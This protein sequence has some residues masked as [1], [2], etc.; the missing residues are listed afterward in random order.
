M[1]LGLSV[2]S[3]L[4][5][6]AVA[7]SQK[8][9]AVTRIHNKSDAFEH[10]EVG[11]ATQYLRST[12][13][14]VEQFIVIDESR[15]KQKL[16]E[17]VDREKKK[18]YKECYSKS[19]QIP[20]G[21]QLAADSLLR[22]QLIQFDS[23][24]CLFS[25]ELIDLA[26]EA[27]IGGGQQIFDCSMDGLLNSIP[28]V[29]EQLSEDKKS[30]LSTQKANCRE[31]KMPASNA[32]GHCCWPGQKWSEKQTKCTGEPECPEGRTASGSRCLADEDRDAVPDKRDDCPNTK[33]EVQTDESGCS[34][35]SASTGDSEAIEAGAESRKAAGIEQ[36]V[37]ESGWSRSTWGWLS[38][39]TGAL[40]L[41]GSAVTF[42]RARSIRSRTESD[43][44]SGD[45][46]QKRA[47]SNEDRV[48]KLQT[49]SLILGVSGGLLTA[50]GVG[51][52]ITS[53]SEQKRENKSVSL[54]F[55]ADEDEVGIQVL[56]AF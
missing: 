25:V 47:I 20:L 56:T 21:Q 26:K 7:Q 17:L 34:T 55:R 10:Q 53:D 22:S 50:T 45:I 27:G 18:S 23:N 41:S 14:S 30:G 42:F 8:K 5:G 4:P 51:L 9:V 32:P 19:C 38:T 2:V 46:T 36:E 6:L 54:G 12:V 13:T 16:E 48:G 49:T 11:K 15:Q 29:V 52:L 28:K 3:S 33:P 43:I 39:G 1:I 37:T 44:E 35:A 40:L 24:R 31:G